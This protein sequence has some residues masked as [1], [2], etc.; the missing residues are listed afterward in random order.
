MEMPLDFNNICVKT[1]PPPGIIR[2]EILRYAGVSGD[3]PELDGII[4]ECITEADSLLTYKVC[5][6]TV[7]VN[8][9]GNEIDFGFFKTDSSDLQKNL[10]GCSAAVIFA[11]TVGAGIDR[12][13]ARYNRISP[14]KGLILQS[15]GTERVE[16]LCDAFNNEINKQM[17]EMGY[18]TRPRFSPGYGDLPLSLQRGIFPLLDCPRKIGLTLNESLLMSPSKSVTAIIGL[19]QNKS[20]VEK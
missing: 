1:Y 16:S 4:N 12:L 6:R 11:A 7:T 5:Y 15:L 13:I 3:T 18:S 19:V 2:K 9:I 14:A 10:S 20:G 17:N 8:K